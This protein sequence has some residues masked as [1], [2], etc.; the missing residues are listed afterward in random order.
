MSETSPNHCESNSATLR[1]KE[2]LPHIESYI[3]CINTLTHLP[4][5][6]SDPLHF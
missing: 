4:R 3:D 1:T 6:S 5:V 2:A